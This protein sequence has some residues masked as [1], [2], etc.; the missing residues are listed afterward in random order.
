[1]KYQLVPEFLGAGEDGLEIGL[2]EVIL[3][4]VGGG[5][6]N[7]AQTGLPG[8]A[9]QL[10]QRQRRVLDRHSDG[11]VNAV[12]IRFVRLNRGVVYELREMRAVG[13]GRPLN[14]RGEN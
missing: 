14:R 10:L 13:R 2:E 7:R 11:P 9:V 8:D 6:V 3:G 4:V 1:M 12:G 5:Q